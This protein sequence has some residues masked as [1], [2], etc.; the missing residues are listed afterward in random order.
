MSQSTASFRFYA[1]LIDFLAGEV[2]AGRVVRSF[3]ESPSVKDQIEAC[4]VP[5]TEV[6]L[7]LVNG[8]SVDFGHR[9]Q[10]GDWVSVYPVFEAFD[11]SAITRV[12]PEPLRDMKFVKIE[13]LKLLP[14]TEFLL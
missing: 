12:R 10:D 7:V 14:H 5:H 2:D 13:C 6:D 4:G 3:D 9:L 8:E 11:I 1:E